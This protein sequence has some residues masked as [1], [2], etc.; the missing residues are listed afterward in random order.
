MHE[1]L[2]RFLIPLGALIVLAPGVSSST[3]LILGVV[4]ALI[5]GNPYREFSQKI[6]HRLLAISVVG[7]GA[8]LN[9]LVVG[10]VGLQGIGYTVI[11]ITLTLSLG[12]LFGRWLKVEKDTSLLISVGTAIC[13]GSA[14]AAVAPVLKAK[15]HEVSVALGIV[16]LLNAIALFLFPPIGH[17]FALDET[18]FGLWSALAIHDT[19]SV[20]GSALQYGPHA[21]Q[22]ATTVKLARALWIVPVALSIGFLRARSSHQG[23]GTGK[24]K[25]PWFILGFVLAAALVTW[26]PSLQPAGHFVENLAKH[27]LVLTLFFIGSNLTKETLKSVGLRPFIQGFFLWI[28]MATG[29]LS[30]LLLGWIH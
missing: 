28:V 29:S 20:V 21:L 10:Q 14:I 22:I 23:T 13:G 17:F 19:S 3:A 15:S 24:A 11:G 5:L 30:A 16:F 12:F 1:K 8:G 25:K 2:A 9:L 27:G 18:Q 6:T 4:L 7:F 26:V